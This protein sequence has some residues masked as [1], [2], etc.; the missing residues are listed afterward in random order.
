MGVARQVEDCR[1]LADSLGWQVAQEYVD[2][3]L[4]AY[5]GKR[6][7]AY[8]Q[9]LTDLAD[10]LRDAVICYHMDRLTRR[11]VESEQFIA[12]VD[13]A[14]VRQVRF[15]S[16]DMDLDTGNGLLIGRIMA[17]VAANESAAKSR[18]VSRKMDQ[19]AAEGRPRGGSRRPFGYE[20]DRV[21]G[22]QEESGRRP[23]HRGPPSYVATSSQGRR[24]APGAPVSCRLRFKN[25]YCWCCTI[26][27]NTASGACASLSRQKM[28][29]Q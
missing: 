24:A 19:I 7:P 21:T 10:G 26:C 11:P 12:T 8:E 25:R 22:R 23:E 27:V 20:D 17:A 18:R 2:N 9:M 28:K 16:G 4:S 29:S 6:R 15:V 1:R 5:S 13:V 14:G 3:D